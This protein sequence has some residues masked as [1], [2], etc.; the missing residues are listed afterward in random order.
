MQYPATWLAITMKLVSTP[1]K[2]Q[3]R[4]NRTK[5][6]STSRHI[7]ETNLIKNISL[8]DFLSN[9]TAE[10]ELTTYQAAKATNRN[11]GTTNKLKK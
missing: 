7:M 9:I 8:K 2:E 6:K 4:I 5:G 1:L 3:M 11:K 10:A